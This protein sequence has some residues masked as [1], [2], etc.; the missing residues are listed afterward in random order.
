MDQ[1]SVYQWLD[2]HP[3]NKKAT[4]NHGFVGGEKWWNQKFGDTIAMIV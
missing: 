4:R 3:I 2:L 1:T